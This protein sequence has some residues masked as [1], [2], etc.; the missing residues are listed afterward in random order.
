M[1]RWAI[2]TVALYVIFLAIAW[3]LIPILVDRAISDQRLLSA[4]DVPGMSSWTDVGGFFTA[5]PYWVWLILA[6]FALAQAV[7]LIVPV[8]VEGGRP[9]KR[10]HIWPTIIMAG[11]MVALLFG[12]AGVAAMIFFNYEFGMAW[13]GWAF[14]GLIAL[15]WLVWTFVFRWLC[16]TTDD[17]KD[18]IS[19]IT[20]WLYM[21]SILELL[22]AVTTHILVRKRGDC[23]AGIVT[24]AGMAAGIA[25]ALLSF[26]P[27]VFYL[28]AAR[29][30]RLMAKSAAE[31]R[32]T[33]A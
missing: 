26:G 13:A 9:V 16:L 20:F 33:Q 2:L 1:K 19:K 17:P 27:G 10:R 28:F 6:F 14:L 4:S 21:G 12:T 22:V 32:S 11:F 30:K 31:Q 18:W 23:C 7:L 15:M 3:A 5:V 24:M 8:R 29:K 25:I